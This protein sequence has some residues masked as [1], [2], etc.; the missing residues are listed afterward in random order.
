ML[1]LYNINAASTGK[2]PPPNTHVI[3]VPGVGHFVAQVKPV[4]F[5]KAL[6]GIIV[7]LSEAAGSTNR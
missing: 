3:M 4:E 1:T 5:N 6:D 7:R 2:E